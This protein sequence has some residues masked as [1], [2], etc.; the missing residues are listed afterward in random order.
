MAKASSPQAGRKTDPAPPM[1]HS[2]D[3]RVAAQMGQFAEF[4]S[5]RQLKLTRQRA[6][7]V[8]EILTNPGHFE[9][10]EIVEQLKRNR[11]RVSR[12]TVYR[13]L[14][15]LKEC[16]LV[17]RLDFGDSAAYYEHVE[18]GAHHD[19]LICLSCGNV[20]EF[21]NAGLERIQA[22]VCANFDFEEHHHS[23]RIF[24]YCSKC[25]QRPA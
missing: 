17:E 12:A 4:L 6:A 8:E 7:V 14:E 13:T 1:Q 11:R 25:R 5:Q 9:A 21:H 16:L 22:S 10:E 15:L 20:I 23:L 19:H 2:A 3:S 24:G 18:E